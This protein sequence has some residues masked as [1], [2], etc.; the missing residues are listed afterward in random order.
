M[1]KRKPTQ[2]Q[3]SLKQS[4]TTGAFL[5]KSDAVAHGKRGWEVETATNQHLRGKKIPAV[6]HPDGWS[7]FDKLDDKQIGNAVA[8]DRD[9]APLGDDDF[10]KNAS[11]IMPVPKQAISIRIDEDVV[12]FFKKNGSGYQSRMNAVLR[13]YM[14]AKK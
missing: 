10:W 2:T 14:E 11:V 1:A 5:K 4:A 7:E 9:A 8:G 12:A 13:S 3:S 6:A